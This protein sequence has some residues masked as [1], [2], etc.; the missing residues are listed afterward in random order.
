MS[1]SSRSPVVDVY[2]QAIIDG[3]GVFEDP[4]QADVM[5]AEADAASDEAARTVADKAAEL[6]L[7][8]QQFCRAFESTPELRMRLSDVGLDLDIRKNLIDSLFKG[9]PE[10]I[11]VVAK[12]L[13]EREELRLLRLIEDRLTVLIEEQFRVV[14]IDVTT[15]VELDDDLRRFIK[16]KYAT[17][18]NASIALREHIDPGIMGG[19]V[20]QVRGRL[21]DASL[22]AQLTRAREV[23]I[24]DTPGGAI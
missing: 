10:I 8:F 16:E 1:I 18:L 3:A 4:G 22:V 21:I 12:L 17:Q 13:V 23:L 2:A 24:S 11:L 7:A 9:M 5:P 6:S 14:I 19:I 20:M 15:V